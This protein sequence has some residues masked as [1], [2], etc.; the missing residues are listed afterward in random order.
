MFV[1]IFKKYSPYVLARVSQNISKN[2]ENEGIGS[3]E[4][5]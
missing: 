1:C 2:V 3:L 5:L 4:G